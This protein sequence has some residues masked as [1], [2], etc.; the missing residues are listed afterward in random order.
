MVYPL[1][2]RKELS[3]YFYRF[4]QR[5][6]TGFD[7]TDSDKEFA[8]VKYKRPRRV[9]NRNRYPVKP[10]LPTKHHLDKRLRPAHRYGEA[11]VP[12]V[13]GPG[14][15]N[16]RFQ[17]SQPAQVSLQRLQ[18]RLQTLQFVKVLG[19][20]GNGIVGLFSI[21]V[22]NAVTNTA[23]TKLVAAKTYLREVPADAQAHARALTALQH[24]IIDMAWFEGSMHCIQLT[25]LPTPNLT[26]ANLVAPFDVQPGE[27]FFRPSPR[28]PTRVTQ[29]ENQLLG[30][31]GHV[32]APQRASS[33]RLIGMRFPPK[34][35]HKDHA[36]FN[37]ETLWNERMPWFPLLPQDGGMDNV[38]FDLDPAN[39][40]VGGFDVGITGHEHP[41]FPI[42]KI[43]DFGLTQAFDREDPGNIL[44]NHRWMW[45]SRT[46]GKI[47]TFTPEQFTE[48]WDWLIYENRAP[49]ECRPEPKVAGR[50]TWKTNLYQAGLTMANMITLSQSQAPPVPVLKKLP[51]PFP[52]A[53]DQT[54][55]GHT[56][57]AY[58]LNDSMDW[59]H[60][61]KDLRSAVAHCLFDD[62]AL[63][64][65][66]E[67]L[68]R[69][70]EKKLGEYQQKS[71]EFGPDNSWQNLNP[72]PTNWH[73]LR[74]NDV[75]Q[76]LWTDGK[77]QAWTTALFSPPPPAQG[78]QAGQ[79]AGQQGGQQADQQGAPQAQQGAGNP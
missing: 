79:Q 35:Y 18:A 10:T 5:G 13:G 7:P 22:V 12:A 33:W 62:P 74:W 46:G 72:L 64:P 49:A 1:T 54:R 19:W 57:G 37:R 2:D 52:A 28:L 73:D 48:E 55:E 26:A 11:F 38:H 65:S 51:V 30:Q 44:Y 45:C 56:Y 15:E 63:R 68:Y 39:I 61:D 53:N 31:N 60:V 78:Q 47:S 29:L 40:F 43:A 41:L 25:D 3:A 66:L 24:E 76:P 67:E 32:L 6:V 16:I 8:Q 36:R 58:L 14:R 71:D 23:Q 69:L 9:P 17:A 77:M 50:Y 59:R 34:A 42:T 21:Q 70:S 4:R 75:M 20:G 27:G